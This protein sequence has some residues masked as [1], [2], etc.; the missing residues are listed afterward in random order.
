MQ[1][2]KLWLKPKIWKSYATKQFLANVF[3]HKNTFN[4]L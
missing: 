2:R 4:D 3:K 1:K